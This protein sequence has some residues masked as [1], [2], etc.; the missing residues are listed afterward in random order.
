MLDV[1]KARYWSFIPRRGSGRRGE[2]T[3]ADDVAPRAIERG[4]DGRALS[5][6]S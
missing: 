6:T 3:S 2:V 4:R 5:P 1:I